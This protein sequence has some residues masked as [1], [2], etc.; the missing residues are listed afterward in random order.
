MLVAEIQKP[1]T[2]LTC[3]VDRMKKNENHVKQIEN[4]LNSSSSGGVTSDVLST[5]KCSTKMIVPD[6]VKVCFKLF[7]VAS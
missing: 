3:L 7:S 5:P 6:E 4:R 1:N 2:I